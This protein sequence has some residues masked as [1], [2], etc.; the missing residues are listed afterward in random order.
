MASFVEENVVSREQLM[1]VAFGTI[2]EREQ[3]SSQPPALLYFR[4]QFFGYMSLLVS[5]HLRTCKYLNAVVHTRM[6]SKEPTK[7]QAQFK[8]PSCG[9]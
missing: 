7:I 1:M 4:L 8:Y 2:C 9:L 3:G 6:K 5:C